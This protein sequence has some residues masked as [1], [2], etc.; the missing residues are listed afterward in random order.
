MLHSTHVK[1]VTDLTHS[2]IKN[3]YKGVLNIYKGIKPSLFQHNSKK[4]DVIER[5]RGVIPVYA[6]P[7]GYSSFEMNDDYNK[8][9]YV[10]PKNYFCRKILT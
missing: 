9:N 1:D 4:A 7:V 5:I 3:V 2:P 10:L 8:N 6:I